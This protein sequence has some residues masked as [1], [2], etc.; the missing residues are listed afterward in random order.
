MFLD[1]EFAFGLPAV[2][3]TGLHTGQMLSPEAIVELQTKA[4]FEAGKQSATNF[5]SFRPR[6]TAEVRRNLRNKGYEDDVIENIEAWLVNVHLLNDENFA[7]YWV[8]Q[9]E[10]FKPRSHFALSMELRQKGISAEIIDTVLAEV[11]E[12]TSVRT[13]AEKR[14]RRLL[15]LPE[16]QFRLKLGRFLQSRGFSY[17]L[18]RPICDEIWQTHIEQQENETQE[19]H[20]TE[21]D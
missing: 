12:E 20:T 19:E 15:H 14:A 11:D 5:I 16:D 9:R 3:A 10:S 7:R 6:S 18:I 4:T 1:D 13:A 17:G 21:W 2:V 8:E